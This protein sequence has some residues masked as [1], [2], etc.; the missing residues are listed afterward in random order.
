M[1]KNAIQAPSPVGV[2]T[3]GAISAVKAVGP[4]NLTYVKR[5][6]LTLIP[7]ALLL[8]ACHH[9][10]A[11]HNAATMAILEPTPAT[12][13]GAGGGAPMQKAPAPVVADSRQSV[14]PL[15]NEPKY[16]KIVLRAYI[17]EKGRAVGPQEIVQEATP[18]GINPAALDNWDHAYIPAANLAIPSGMGSPISAVAPTVVAPAGDL[19]VQ[20]PEDVE[21]TPY[22]RPEDRPI[23]ESLARQKGCV[24]HFD[25]SLGWVLLKK[26]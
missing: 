24:A 13:M 16:R 1:T 7:A 22:Y 14:V 18:G 19:L 9:S 15:I 11:A 12:A 17:D 26:K 6:L 8:T 10:G 4:A 2:P 3:P 25:S 21:V 20:S 23:V 5:V